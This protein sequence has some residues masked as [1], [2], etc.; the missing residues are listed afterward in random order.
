MRLGLAVLRK[1][2]TGEYRPMFARDGFILR[3]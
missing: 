3:V 2:L 1:Y